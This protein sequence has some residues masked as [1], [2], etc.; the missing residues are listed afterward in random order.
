M[1]RTLGFRHFPTTRDY[2]SNDALDRYS[3]ADLDDRSSLPELSRAQRL[4]A[5]RAMDRRDRGLPGARAARRDRAPAFLQS[6]DEEE[7]TGYGTGL[8]DG[9]ERR[10]RRRQYD[11]RPEDDDVDE[12]DVSFDLWVYRRAKI[13]AC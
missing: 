4:A 1:I 9:I 13:S 8:L 6:D 12:E 7:A 3:E 2:A 5:E 10:R 11:E